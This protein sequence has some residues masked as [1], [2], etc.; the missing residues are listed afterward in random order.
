MVC[1]YG[2]ATMTHR[3]TFALNQTSV[4]HLKTLSARLQVSQSEVLRRALARLATE[5]TPEKP[6]PVAMLN[7][8]HASGKGMDPAEAEA[9]LA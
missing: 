8:L 7:A 3:T 2:M 6:D 1:S 5:S 9:Y 4:D